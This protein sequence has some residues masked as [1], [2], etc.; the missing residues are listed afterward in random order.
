MNI[1]ESIEKNRSIIETLPSNT[2]STKAKK[3]EFISK[4]VEAFENIKETILAEMKKRF[5]LLNDLKENP[6]IVALKN[7]ESKLE[8]F[9]EWNIYNT[10]YE[11]MHLDYYLYH[12][13]RFYKEDFK[14]VNTC[15][16]SLL[17]SFA[18]VG[19]TLTPDDFYYHEYAKEYI[20]AII[21]HRDDERFIH[22]VFEKIYWKCS[23]IIKILEI[24]FKSLYYKN[25]KLIEK[26]YADRKE[27]ILSTHNESEIFGAYYSTRLKRK[28]LEAVD[29][30]TILQKFINKEVTTS[31][32]NSE[33]LQ[34]KKIL[35]FKEDPSDILILLEKMHLSLEEYEWYN[36]YY[37]FIEDMRN[38][39]KNKD[40][41]KGLL[42]SKLKEKEKKEKE[43]F[44]LSNKNQG[45]LGKFKKASDNT[46]KILEVVNTLSELYTSLDDIRFNNLIYEKLEINSVISDILKMVSSN[47]LYF[48]KM[49]KSQN[50]GINIKDV[51]LEHK[52]FMDAM[53]SSIFT[54]LNNI[55]VLDEKNLAEIICD[56]YKLLNVLLEVTDLEASNLSNFLKDVEILM[57][58]NNMQ[59]T[60][61]SGKD[62]EFYLEMKKANLFE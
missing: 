61:F 18:N 23:D 58:G 26:F 5:S 27:K 22:D 31:D 52:D 13:H 11:K 3:K 50:E 8:L 41:Y 17:Q 43:L 47:Y 32:V 53:H 25:E 39:I 21:N 1:E 44:S 20:N 37:F 7:E 62:I 45:L 54:I 38:R 46:F 12:L 29:E 49:K 6:E 9:K 16:F 24:N 14:S 36:K 55:Y 51:T 28:S 35:I 4:E 57:L 48:V 56:R 10:P 59:K 42:D 2:I 15:I 30:Y 34:R 40:Q 33:T 19:I 60:R